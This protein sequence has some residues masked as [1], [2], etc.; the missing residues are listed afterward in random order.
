MEGLSC[1]L[2]HFRGSK[3]G[4]YKFSVTGKA[5]SRSQTNYIWLRSMIIDHLI[6]LY[7]RYKVNQQVENY[8]NG[9]IVLDNNL[10]KI[11]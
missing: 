10:S 1:G 5:W 6:D 3:T 11:S 2:S 9:I 7:K 4:I 8:C